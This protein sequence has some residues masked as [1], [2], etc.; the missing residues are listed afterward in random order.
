MAKVF[1][2]V[3]GI[4]FSARFIKNAVQMK[5][6]GVVKYKIKKEGESYEARE[7]FASEFGIDEESRERCEF[8]QGDA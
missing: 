3:T 7:V 8:W 1:E 6:Q 2:S 4:D 5:E